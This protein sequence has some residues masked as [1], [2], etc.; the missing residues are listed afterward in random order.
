MKSNDKNKFYETVWFCVLMLFLFAPIGIVLLWR[1]KHFSARI[2]VCF[3]VASALLFIV[4]LAVPSENNISDFNSSQNPNSLPVETSD[5]VSNDA[6]E[7][8]PASS[9]EYDE[10]Q[11][12]YLDLD[13]N[14]GYEAMLDLVKSTKLPYSE[15]KYNGSRQV[16]VA[17]TEGCTV[18]NHKKEN[19][20]YLEI[21]YEYPDDKNSANDVLSN[22][23]FGTCAYVPNDSDLCLISHVSGVYFSYYE[24]GNYISDFGK[25]LDLDKNMSKKE[26][27]DYY[28]LNK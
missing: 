19:G 23:S 15:Q 7:D 25:A 2:N 8:S 12:L 1:Y 27:L 14:M 21:I 11:Q 28:F 18:Q 10:L 4:F 6:T 22:Y 20:D 26:Q 24:P 5:S 16:Q 3:S 9:F 13:P 17:F